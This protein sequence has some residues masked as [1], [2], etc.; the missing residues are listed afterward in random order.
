MRRGLGIIVLATLAACSGN[1]EEAA[2]AVEDGDQMLSCAIG[3]GSEFSDSC[4]L[5][6]FERDGA[7]IY[8]VNHPGGGFRL[9]DVAA[10]GSGLVPHDGAESAANALD[11][12]VL[13]VAIGEDRYRFPAR[14]NA[15]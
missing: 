12:D 7:T 11:G 6:K 9:F 4:T 15:R 1:E 3:P 2:N 8:R 14:S 10:D 5:Q 13:E